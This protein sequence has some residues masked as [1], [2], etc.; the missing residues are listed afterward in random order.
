MGEWLDGLAGCECSVEY[1][2]MWRVRVR[3][4]NVRWKV[5]L[6]S[7]LLPSPQACCP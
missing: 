6:L 7:T 5:L 3:A 4:R 2:K 1:W